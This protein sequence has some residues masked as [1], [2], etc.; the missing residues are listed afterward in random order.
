MALPPSLIHHQLHEAAYLNN[1]SI[2]MF[3]II[4]SPNIASELRINSEKQIA[5]QTI[6]GIIGFM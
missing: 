6:V 2:F 1:I 4:F 5:E 3:S